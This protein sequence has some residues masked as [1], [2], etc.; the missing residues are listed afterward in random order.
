MSRA[1]P[2]ANRVTICPIGGRAPVLDL[3]RR[4]ADMHKSGNAL[5][6]LETERIQHAA[7]IG[8]PFG[9]PIGAVAERVSGEHQAH[10][11]GAGGQHLL[12][13]RNFHVRRRRG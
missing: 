1:Q 2:F 6:L 4:P 11:G 7:V 13:F 12:P 8:V 10:G 5:V 9:D 3:L